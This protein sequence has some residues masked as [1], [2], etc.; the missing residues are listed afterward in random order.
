MWRNN[1]IKNQPPRYEEFNEEHGGKSLLKPCN[2]EVTD[3][4]TTVENIRNGSFN[5]KDLEEVYFMN[6]LDLLSTLENTKKVEDEM[7]DKN[8]IY[9]LETKIDKVCIIRF[10]LSVCNEIKKYL[11][12]K[13][14]DLEIY[15]TN[16][17]NSRFFILH[18]KNLDL[19]FNAFLT[20]LSTHIEV[21]KTL[22]GN[23]LYKACD[24]S[25]MLYVLDN[26]SNSSTHMKK[27]NKKLIKKIIK[28]NFQ[29]NC[30][31]SS[32]TNKFHFENYAKMFKYHDIYFAQQLIY[33]YLNSDFY[34]YYDIYVKTYNEMKNHLS[35][36]SQNN[37]H[38]EIVDDS[39]DI[40]QILSSLDNSYSLMKYMETE[41][42]KFNFE[43]L[44]QY[45]IDEETYESDVSDLLLGGNYYLNKKK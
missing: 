26:P 32:K 2:P 8:N 5:Y 17:F 25:Q 24:I 7:K 1:L 45:N 42:G 23:N 35:E 13:T 37:K 44:L 21:H 18:L 15:P 28:N 9:V 19:K 4:L 6:D 41:H 22:D 38:S 30:G 3:A 11:L 40:S 29:L 43:T 31:I 33:E 39:T 10:P 14:L 34:D 36:E 16:L 12:N 20:E 27:K